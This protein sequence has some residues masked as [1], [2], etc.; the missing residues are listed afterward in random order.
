MQ[1]ENSTSEPLK[2]P[3]HHIA[4]QTSQTK[5]EKKWKIRK[6]MRQSLFLGKILWFIALLIPTKC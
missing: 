4:I 1:K 5:W 3:N 2:W 6:C